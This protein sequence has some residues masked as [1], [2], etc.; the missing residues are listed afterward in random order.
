MSESLDLASTIGTWIGAGVGI[1]ALIGIVGPALIWYAST[2]ERQK[3]LNAIGR[4]SNDYLSPGY[5]LGPNIWLF[6]R[7]RAP[8]LKHAKSLR[9]FGSLPTLDASKMKPIDTDTS[10]ISFGSLLEAYGIPFQRG[11]SLLIKE[12]RTLLPI[13]PSWILAIGLLGRYSD[14]KNQSGLPAKKVLTYRLGIPRRGI[15]NPF[16]PRYS[17]PEHVR[18][19]LHNR[20]GDTGEAEDRDGNDFSTLFGTTGACGFF[21]MV[22]PDGSSLRTVRFSLHTI[23]E[24][25]A[26]SLDPKDLL[27]LSLGFLKTSQSHYVCVTQFEEMPE[28]SSENSL[29]SSGSDG[30][31]THETP[32]RQEPSRHQVASMETSNQPYPHPPTQP[33]HNLEI[34]DLRRR[35]PGQAMRQTLLHRPVPYQQMSMPYYRQPKLYRLRQ[36]EPDQEIFQIGG[37]F[38]GTSPIDM[39]ILMPLNPVHA[40]PILAEISPW[41][42]LPADSNWVRISDVDANGN[43]TGMGKIYIERISAQR[44]AFGLLSLRWHTERYLL[45]SISQSGA[46]GELFEA[47]ARSL[48]KFFFRLST[49]LEWLSLS[50]ANKQKLS[51]AL[52]SIRAR[53][54]A[55]TGARLYTAARELDAV[56]GE[57]GS[58]REHTFV[59]QIVAVLAITNSE[60]RSLV[61]DSLRNLRETTTS[62]V[63]LEMPSATLKVPMA[64]GVMQHFYVDWQE[65]F[66]EDIRNHETIPVSYTVVVLAA[67]RSLVKCQMLLSCPDSRPLIHTVAGLGDVVHMI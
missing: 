4:D 58:G 22:M 26:D 35:V 60:F 43:D 28:D 62:L 52:A 63:Q 59:D 17:G 34:T 54:D 6:Q 3:T 49:G 9:A 37:A 57:L 1:I 61:Y 24:V 65:M 29:S 41:S 67:T 14:Q 25:S 66:P 31:G 5:H 10:W 21:T 44:L 20:P 51:S 36:I 2:Q 46:G 45:P 38:F 16:A 32:I 13:H 8:M 53:R 11:D 56:L 50:Q 42:K 7:V 18:A 33:T 55:G 12:G 64:F 40:A 30:E 23:R 47:A 48:Y 39:F 15:G 19:S 27:L